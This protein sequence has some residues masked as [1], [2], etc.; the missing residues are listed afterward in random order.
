MGV[1][2]VRLEVRTQTGGYLESLC[3]RTKG[4]GV[5]ILDCCVRTMWMVLTPSDQFETS[6]VI[7][8]FSVS[9]N[10]SINCF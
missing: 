7:I 4:M 3:L 8:V 10:F 5:K 9:Y 2:K 1:G 6:F